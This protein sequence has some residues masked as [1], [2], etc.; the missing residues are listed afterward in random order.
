VKN[1]RRLGPFEVLTLSLFA[2]FLSFLKFNPCRADEFSAV[3]TLKYF[4]YS[5]IPVFW[6]SRALEYHTWPFAFSQVPQLGTTINPVE[7]PVV[8][9][10][11]IW[12]LSYLTDTSRIAHVHYFDINIIF[13]SLLFA[14]SSV[15]LYKIKQKYIGLILFTPAVV[16]ALFINWDMWAVLPT[17]LAIYCFD[18]IKITASGI[19]LAIAV[20]AKFYPIVLLIP[21]LILLLK[22]KDYLGLRKYL[23]SFLITYLILNLPFAI[24]NF[25]GWRFFFDMSFNRGTGYGSIWEVFAILGINLSHLNVYYA[26]SSIFVFIA[27]SIFFWRNSSVFKLHQISFLFVFAFTVFSKVYSPQYVLWLT[28]LAILAINSKKQLKAFV[29]WQILESTY[30]LAIWRYFYVLGGGQEMIGVS[31]EIYAL[32]S[33]TRLLT[34]TFFAWSIMSP[35]M[36]FKN[37]ISN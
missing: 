33:F 29:L 12:I 16:M 10:I 14:I 22:N 6:V 21:K 1:I 4:C 15:Y 18:R 19:F 5:D 2:S 17:I 30:H 35:V 9:G 32:I 3:S 27:V 11:V 20:S 31:P 36:Q 23:A 8:V 25:Q 28:P 13:L 26:L 34:M 37:K 7:Y 24:A